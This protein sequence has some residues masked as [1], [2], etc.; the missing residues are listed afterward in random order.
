MRQEELLKEKYGTDAGYRVPDGYFESLTEKIMTEL[1][2]YPKAP[3]AA[4]MTLWQRM[5]PYV[6][7]A[8]M[9][10]GIWVMMKVFHTVATS[11]QLSFDNPPA[12]I[13]QALDGE[14][15]DFLELY[16]GSSDFEL[17]QELI[18]SYDSFEEF[19]EDFTTAAE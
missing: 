12:A 19:K 11:D 7:L 10:A 4:P 13:V 1:P 16:S 5:K 17:E 8:A 9:F 18:D 14:N 2:D 15:S 6:Y 3:V